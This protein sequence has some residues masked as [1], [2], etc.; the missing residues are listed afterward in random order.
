[1]CS[2]VEAWEEIGKSGFK[3][4]RFRLLYNK[5]SNEKEINKS[6]TLD[7]KD[8]ETS[9]KATTILRIVRESKIAHQIK[10]LYDYKCQV[11][12]TSLKVKSGY[13]AEGAHIRSLGSPHNGKDNIDNLL[14]LCPN[15]HVLFD[16]GS[17]AIS[18]EM[19]LIGHEEGKLFVLPD[20]KINKENLE[21]HRKCFGYD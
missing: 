12:N 18:N 14:C 8:R 5:Y 9:R 13:Y 4:C 7:Y 2:V 1:M 17:F 3:I 11:C 19:Q 16:R 6:I 10:E 21:Y 20:H 15:H